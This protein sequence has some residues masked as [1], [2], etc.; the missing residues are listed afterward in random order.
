MTTP[1]LIAL[2]FMVTL[3]VIAAVTLRSSLMKHQGAEKQ[4]AEDRILVAYL[5]LRRIVG[6]LGI[7]LPIVVV[8]WGFFLLD[9]VEFL[10]SISD[11]YSIRTRDAFVGILFLVGWFLFAYRGYD[12]TDD[13]AGDWAWAFALGVALFPNSGSDWERIVHFSSALALFLIL[14]F[15]CLFLFTK[16]NVDRDKRTTQKKKRNKIYRICGVIILLSLVA[17][18]LSYL[19]MEEETRNAYKLVLVF[20]SVMLWA[21]GTSWIVKGEWIRS[22]KDPENA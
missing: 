19:L 5:T 14:A 9:G 22:L 4:V 2:A 3:I 11:Y 7:G 17:I 13:K 12:D 15:F 18:G 10:N 1:Q 6:V 8:I 16:S 21:F 20:E